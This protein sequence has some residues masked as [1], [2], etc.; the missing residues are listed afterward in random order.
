MCFIEETSVE[1]DMHVNGPA[2]W[3]RSAQ[4]A[5]RRGVEAKSV[6]VRISS[7]QESVAEARRPRTPI[8][9]LVVAT[10]V[11]RETN[12]C[13]IKVCNA[14]TRGAIYADLLDKLGISADVMH[15][16]ILRNVILEVHTH[17]IA[18]SV[19]TAT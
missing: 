5:A 6:T 3:K 16:F 10:M 9:A 4:R 2:T 17:R 11:S 14:Q 15:R 1:R 18:P 13:I 7:G 8:R 12:R 19:R